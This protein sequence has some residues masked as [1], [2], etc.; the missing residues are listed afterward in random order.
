MTCKGTRTLGFR[1]TKIPF[2]KG[3]PLGTV[4][5]TAIHGKV[6]DKYPNLKKE[7]RKFI[8]YVEL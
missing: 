3:L 2:G 6:E 1:S 4:S 8:K 5:K 7:K